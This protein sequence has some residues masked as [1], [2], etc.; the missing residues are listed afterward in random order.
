ME[1]NP[2]CG[3]K[4]FGG[5]PLLGDNIV[6]MAFL[7]ESGTGSVEREPRMVLA[8]VILHADKQ[9]KVVENYL[10]D[11]MARHCPIPLGDLPVHY[12]FHATEL[13]SGGKIFSRELVSKEK[14]WAILDELASLPAKFELPVVGMYVDR[15]ENPGTITQHYRGVFVEVAAQVEAYMRLL[16]DRNEVA[17]IIAEDLP[18]VRTWVDA[19]QLYQ[20]KHMDTSGLHAGDKSRLRLTRVIGRPHFES[21]SM[22]SP[23]QLAD[24]CAWAIRRQIEKLP[25]AERFFEPLVPMIIDVNHARPGGYEFQGPKRWI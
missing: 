14:R 19:M 8:G 2:Y 3:P 25:N 22:Y 9:W 10:A 20:Q 11:M 15:R 21:K 12:G 7:D 17:S 16:P 6:R 24:F 13:Y 1:S 4:A 23:L 18:P 5:G